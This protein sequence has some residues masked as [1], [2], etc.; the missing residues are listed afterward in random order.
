MTTE[1]PIHKKYTCSNCATEGHNS[2]GC[3]LAYDRTLNSGTMDGFTWNWWNKSDKKVKKVKKARKGRHCSSCGESGHNTRTCGG[4]QAY[5]ARETVSQEMVLGTI[6]VSDN[7]ATLSGKVVLMEEYFDAA[8]RPRPISKNSDLNEKRAQFSNLPSK[9]PK[10]RKATIPHETN[11]SVQVTQTIDLDV[12]DEPWVWAP[13][14]PINR[15]LT[16]GTD[17]IRAQSPIILP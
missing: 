7:E 3:P 5:N 15:R 16:L 14:R 12:Y 11:R 4:E 17:K 6:D 2:R 9:I 8:P 13:I 10:R 1:Q